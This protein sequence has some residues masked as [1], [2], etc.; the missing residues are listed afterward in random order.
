MDI[1]RSLALS[2][3]ALATLALAAT[4]AHAEPTK[5]GAR[6]LE[7]PAPAGFVPVSKDVPGYMAFSQA[8]LP[9]SNRLVEVYGPPASKAAMMAGEE[10]RLPRYFQLQV[11]RSVEGQP[12]SATDF[13]A[14]TGQMEAE[15]NAQ[16]AR[17]DE[18]AARLSTQGNDAMR[19]QTQAE[20]TIGGVQFHGVYRREPWGLFFTTSTQLSVEEGGRTETVPMIGANAL[21]LVDH[22]LMYL[23]AFANANE[24]DARAVAEKSASAWADAVRAANPDDPEVAARAQP[25][26]TPSS[27][28]PWLVRGA[29]FGGV[30]GL[31]VFLVGWMQRRRGSR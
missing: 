18:A 11:L 9:A 10:Q 12:V 7:I 5:F 16:M 25:M 23:Y 21:V 13:A 8:Y 6:T 31:I 30:F 24:P 19:D 28:P 27:I 14:A 3:A 26:P 2:I 22:Q 20:V 4:P 1:R 29:V 17:A 15:I